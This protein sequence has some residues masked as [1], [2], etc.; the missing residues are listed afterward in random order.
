MVA[1]GCAISLASTSLYAQNKTITLCW[2][3]WDPANAL[4]ELSKDFTAKTGVQMKFEF[5]P[6]PN[7][8]DRMLNEL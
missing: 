1:A 2:A 8:A 7:F 6:W 3:A 5:V 4:V